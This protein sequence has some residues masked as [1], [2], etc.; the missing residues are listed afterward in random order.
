MFCDA[1]GKLSLSAVAEHVNGIQLAEMVKQ[2]LEIELLSHKMDIEEP[3]AAS[4]ISQALNV[5]QEVV[6][7]IRT[8]RSLGFKRRDARADG[9]RPQ[10][11]RSLQEC[12]RQ[13][14]S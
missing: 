9:K 7:F 5:A 12:N 8:Y 11:G 6:A 13:G 10:P 4:T 14:A 2:G 3:T 1:Q